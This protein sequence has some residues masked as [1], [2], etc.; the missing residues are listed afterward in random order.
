MNET[1]TLATLEAVHV[2]DEASCEFVA[3][4]ELIRAFAA[5]SRDTNP[6][7]LD[8]QSA[9]DLGFPQP[10]A[11]GMIALSAV[12]RLIGT[13]LPGP[14][15]LWISQEVRFVA[16]VLLGDAVTVRVIVERVSLA[17]GIVQLKTEASHTVRGSLLLTGTARVRVPG[18]NGAA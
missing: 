6:L 10:V 16:P 14:G 4:E 8:A 13:Q 7:H 11:H 12:S 1:T 3:T 15:S 18:R 2:G 5:F 17:T 9:R